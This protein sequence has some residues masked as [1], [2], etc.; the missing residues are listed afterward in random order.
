MKTMLDE[1]IQKGHSTLRGH[2]IIWTGKEWLY[3]D[4][5]KKIEDEEIRPCKKCGKIF[6]DS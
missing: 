1:A 4:T 3:D 6:E 5:R 2:K